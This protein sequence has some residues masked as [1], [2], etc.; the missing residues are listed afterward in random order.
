MRFVRVGVWESC[1]NYFQYSLAFGMWGGKGVSGNRV[2]EKGSFVELSV[3]ESKSCNMLCKKIRKLPV[4]DNVS[5]AH[6]LPLQKSIRWPAF[7]FTHV[8][9]CTILKS[10]F[11]GDEETSST[12]KIMRYNSLSKN[13]SSTVIR[14]MSC[15]L[16]CR[17]LEENKWSGFWLPAGIF[18]KEEAEELAKSSQR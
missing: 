8:D 4:R 16:R 15:L 12:R 6:G 14:K 2:F 18:W 17:I 9:L 7:K 10:V 11:T 3:K 13:W 1:Q 5:F